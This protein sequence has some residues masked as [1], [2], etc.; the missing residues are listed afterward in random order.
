MA[1]FSLISDKLRRSNFFNIE[2]ERLR[3]KSLSYNRSLHRNLR[4]YF[5]FRLNTIPRNS[6]RVR[7]KNRCL[8]TNRG[9]G[10]FRFFQISRICLKEYVGVNFISSLKKSSW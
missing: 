5:S 4:V 3:L 8:I 9:K 6:S 2:H 1:K 10:I 7:I